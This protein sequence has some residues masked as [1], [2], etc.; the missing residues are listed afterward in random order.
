VGDVGS[1]ALIAVAM[2]SRAAFLRSGRMSSAN[3]NLCHFL[4][5]PEFHLRV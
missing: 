4:L 2:S 5:S 3:S 1:A